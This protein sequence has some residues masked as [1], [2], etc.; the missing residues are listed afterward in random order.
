MAKI[1]I[2]G[3]TNLPDSVTSIEL[4]ADLLGFNFY[5]PSP[6]YIEPEKAKEI[7]SES[8]S[9]IIT[10]GVFVNETPEQIAAVLRK[11]SLDI[12][13]LHGNETNADCQKVKDIGVKV[14]KALRIR[15]KEDIDNID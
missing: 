10:V 14:I 4:G 11:C 1:K 15:K 3:I 5:P 9:N 6:R 12:V 13:Q 8:K 2:C 7:I